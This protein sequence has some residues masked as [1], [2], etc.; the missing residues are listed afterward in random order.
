M[1]LILIHAFIRT[2]V[3]IFNTL[4]TVWLIYGKTRGYDRSLPH[5]YVLLNM[6]SE[7]RDKILTVCKLLIFQD[8]HKFI[9]ADS[10]YRAVRKCSAYQFAGILDVFVTGL[11]TLCVIDDLEVI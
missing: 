11:M 6:F 2:L 9:S 1:G 8:N 4:I 5:S 10:E 3:N 7:C